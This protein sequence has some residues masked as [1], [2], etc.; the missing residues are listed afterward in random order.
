MYIPLYLIEVFHCT[1]FGQQKAF[2]WGGGGGETCIPLAFLLTEL[3][4][5]EHVEAVVLSGTQ[6][7][8]QSILS[9]L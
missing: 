8:Y 5:M 4:C 6:T 2:F 1:N 9:V 3:V 7:C